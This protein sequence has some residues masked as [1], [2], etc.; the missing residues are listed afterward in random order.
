MKTI[1]K[2]GGMTCDGCVRAVTRAIQRRDPAS[3]VSVDLSAG[4]VSVEGS[5]PP[6]EIRRA[7]EEAG[8]SFEG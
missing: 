5:L 3:T 4:R 2:V 1:Y 8:F 7:V 6:A